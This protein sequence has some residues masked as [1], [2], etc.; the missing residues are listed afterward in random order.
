MK[1]RFTLRDWLWLVV[2]IALVLAW[3]F[4]KQLWRTDKQQLLTRLDQTIQERE[5]HK[6]SAARSVEQANAALRSINGRDQMLMKRLEQGAERAVE[7]SRRL[8]EAQSKLE[9]NNAPRVDDQSVRKP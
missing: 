4:D 8:E 1:F 9:S 7:L 2:V 5:W 6:S 3:Y